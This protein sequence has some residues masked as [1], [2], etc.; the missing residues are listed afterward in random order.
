VQKV[1]N[2]ADDSSFIAR[3]T[4]FDDCVQV[5][6]RAQDFCDSGVHGEQSDTAQPPFGWAVFLEQIVIID[7]LMGAMKSANSDV[8]D[9]L[10]DPVTIIGRNANARR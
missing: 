4:S 10:A 9:P 6:L 5:V 7:S 1:L 3:C 2:R 8:G